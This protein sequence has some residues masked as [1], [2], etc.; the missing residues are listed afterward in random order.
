MVDGTRHPRGECCR[1]RAIVKH[2]PVLPGV[3]KERFDVGTQ[4]VLLPS[5]PDTPEVGEEMRALADRGVLRYLP[6]GQRLA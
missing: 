2:R 1:R 4:L 3:I 5:A 6:C